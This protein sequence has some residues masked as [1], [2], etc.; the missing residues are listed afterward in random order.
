MQKKDLDTYCLWETRFSFK[1]KH[2]LKEKGWEKI[3]HIMVTRRKVGVAILTSIKMKLKPKL[4][5]ETKKELL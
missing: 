4:S 2:R 5:P 3:S 1:E